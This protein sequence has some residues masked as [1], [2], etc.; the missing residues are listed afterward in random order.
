MSRADECQ[1]MLSSV[2]THPARGGE[3]EEGKERGGKGGGLGENLATK[4]RAFDLKVSRAGPNLISP[5]K[6]GA[7]CHTL[8]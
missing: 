5:L 8:V 4:V 6:L 1:N 2:T 7:L 3:K